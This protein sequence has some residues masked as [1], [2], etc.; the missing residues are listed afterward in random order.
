MRDQPASGPS[1]DVA[2]FRA[3]GLV[4]RFDRCLLLFL[5]AV[6]L[7]CSVPAKSGPDEARR[8]RIEAVYLEGHYSEALGQMAAYVQD[9]PDDALGQTILGNIQQDLDLNEAAR[10]SYQRA[11]V[12]EPELVQALTGMG[13]VSRALGDLDKA[14]YW[15]ERALAL[16]PDYAQAWSSLAVIHLKRNDPAAAV[17]VGERAWALDASDPVIAANLAVSYHY[18]GDLAKRD[19]FHRTAVSMG[20]RNG[21]TLE[22]IYRGEL[23]VLGE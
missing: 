7:A 12:L 1:R 13:V 3:E 11:L 17:A 8:G 2:H 22:E 6:I 16:D 18:V 21:K 23:T 19:E 4:R 14:V 9:H 20:Y 15:Y 5:V 10:E